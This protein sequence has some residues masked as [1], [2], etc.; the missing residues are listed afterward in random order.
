ML[1]DSIHAAAARSAI[2]ARPQ[3]IQFLRLARCNDFHL[4][5]LGVAHPAAQVKHT[6]L[7]LDEPAKANPLHTALYEKVKNQFYLNKE[8]ASLS[9]S[10]VF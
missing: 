9:T 1:D 6:G 2:E 4:A 8:S 10:K 3:L 5:V 7:T